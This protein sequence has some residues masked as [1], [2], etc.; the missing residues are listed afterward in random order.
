MVHEYRNL[1]QKNQM[2]KNWC[3]IWKGIYFKI[4]HV[5]SKM[6]VSWFSPGETTHVSG[7][8]FLKSAIWNQFEPVESDAAP[9][10]LISSFNLLACELC[11]SAFRSRWPTEWFRCP[12]AS[13]RVRQTERPQSAWSLVSQQPPRLSHRW[14]CLDV[15]MFF[16]WKSTRYAPHIDCRPV[17]RV[18]K[19]NR[20]TF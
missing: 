13:W 14:D 11:V 2:S 3:I 4:Y 17:R 15:L 19:R 16:Q 8:S 6:I 9:L 1:F 20:S 10:S 12:M 7:T 18:H 5:H